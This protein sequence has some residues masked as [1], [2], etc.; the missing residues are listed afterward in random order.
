MLEEN[1]KRFLSAAGGWSDIDGNRL[2]KDIYKSRTR[3]RWDI[4][5]D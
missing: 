3:G 2:I 4:N 1:K 5:F